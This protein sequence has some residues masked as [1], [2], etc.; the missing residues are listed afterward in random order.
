MAQQITGDVDARHGN[1]HSAET[2][3]IRYCVPPHNCGPSLIQPLSF[4]D[5]P[6]YLLSHFTG[7]DDQLDHITKSFAT[8]HGYAP[9]RLAIHGITGIGKTQLAV[10]YAKLSYN[11]QQYSVI[12]WISGATI[13]KVNQGFARILALVE[14]PDR[15]HPEQ[16]TRLALARRWLEDNTTVKWLLILDNVV[17]EVVGFLKEHFPTRNA[18]GNILLTT[19][20]AAVAEA[21]AT[22]D[23]HQIFDLRAPDL[24]DATDQFLK[25]AGIDRSVSSLYS[26]TRAKDLVTCVGCHPLAISHIASFA[27]PTCNNLDEVLAMYQGEQRYEVGCNS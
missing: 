14:H 8:R 2:M 13:E 9:T 27:K 18:L 15:G 11:R 20:S 5:A 3:H 19:R 24:R 22:G 21:V 26:M 4:N 25:E 23:Q 16:S 6:V 10:Q 12:F 7:R 1:Y 17:E